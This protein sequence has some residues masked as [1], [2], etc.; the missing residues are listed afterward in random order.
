MQEEK[1]MLTAML[2]SLPLSRRQ[3][4]FSPVFA[5]LF[6]TFFF[7]PSP[8]VSNSQARLLPEH[9]VFTEHQLL[10]LFFHLLIILLFSR[11]FPFL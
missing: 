1:E 11:P 8:C 9:P 3:L 10:F 6:A 4:G 7:F 2:L 5:S